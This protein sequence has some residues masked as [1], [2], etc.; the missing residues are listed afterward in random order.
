[1]STNKTSAYLVL[2]RLW[3]G[4]PPK[5]VS[6]SEHAMVGDESLKTI[7][8]L[9][10][11][12]EGDY[13]GASHRRTSLLSMGA[14]TARRRED[15]S[16]EFAKADE[17]PPEPDPLEWVD[18]ANEE[19]QAGVASERARLA[20]ENQ[21]A[22]EARAALDAPIVAAERAGFDHRLDEA[23]L[24]PEKLAATIETAV[25][26]ALRAHGLHKTDAPGAGSDER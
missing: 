16:I 17:F 15:G 3:A 26:T 11:L 1:M 7:I 19:I 6:E 23:G 24:S 9:C 20:R 13:A 22:R 21:L 2:K 10:G 12:Y 25:E 18:R 5:M 8:R 4:L 14:L